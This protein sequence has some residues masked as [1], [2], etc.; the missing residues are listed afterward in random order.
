[1][2]LT[3]DDIKMAYRAILGRLPS[4][5]EII[6]TSNRHADLPSVRSTFLNSAE[7]KNAFEKAQKIQLRDRPPTLIH[8]HIPKTAGTT[9]A[10]ALSNSE[11]LKPNLIIHD[12]DIG[13]L[14]S[15]P[16]SQR[17]ALRYI[18]GHLSHGVG[19]TLGFPYRYLCLIRRPGPRIFSFYQFIRRT[20][21]HPA[22]QT[23]NAKP[24]N[25][26]DYLE[27]SQENIPHRMELD[28]G[29]IRRIAGAF[30]HNSIGRE[31]QILKEAMQKALDPLLL[32]GFVE[33]IDT[34]LAR[35]VE[36]GYLPT[37][38]IRPHNVSPTSEEYQTSLDSL[39]QHQRNIFD[40]YTAWD[41]YFYEVCL[42]LLHID[43][44]FASPIR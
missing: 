20:R 43:T 17:R 12:A 18:R 14:R 22:F 11:H 40:N 2:T 25:F 34:F 27:F 32:F 15:L 3:H 10:E 21:T 38:D 6:D 30:D 24:M 16:Q 37:T 1:M 33:K 36:E 19:E 41:T 35:L 4:D 28:N 8:L 26:G 42:Q 44:E 5:A 31:Q 29:Q 9:I 39:T 7:F 13:M 23:L